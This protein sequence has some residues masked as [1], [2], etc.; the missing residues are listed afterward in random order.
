METIEQL[1]QDN[2]KLQERLNNAAKFFRDQKAQIE[3]LI[4][5]KEDLNKQCNEYELKLQEA[6]KKIEER[7]NNLRAVEN[8]TNEEVKKVT[9]ARDELISKCKKLENDIES[10]DKA[11]EVLQN[12]YNEVWTENKQLKEQ[13]ENSKNNLEDLQKQLDEYKL[14][15]Q[16]SE[17]TYKQ[18]YK[19]YD[20]RNNQIA[21]LTGNLEVQKNEYE[22][23]L[24]NSENTCEKLQK[25]YNEV[26][27]ENKQLK[28]QIASMVTE[29]T[30]IAEE[31]AKVTLSLENYK[32]EN[33]TLKN[34][35]KILNEDV[36]KQ[37]QEIELYNELKEKYDKLNQLYD[38][39]ENEKMAYTADL[40]VLQQKYNDKVAQEEANLEIG[41]DLINTLQ[42]IWTICDD[43]LNPKPKEEKKT[44]K[45][46]DIINKVKD[47]TGNQFMSDAKG[48]NI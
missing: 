24:Q 21:E 23:K 9:E 47:S 16:D 10:K 45:Q 37:N 38:N 2:A 17:A 5:E 44:N 35:I 14:K 31:Y 4:K 3:T 43:K 36:I 18:L 1:K 8:T 28:E 12:T 20:V 25:K 29:T 26:S 48:M 40:D 15:L 19:K 7:V 32:N 33:I 13:T 34:D 39:L 46:I 22:L 6:E 11:Y 27:T 41:T 30:N 42:N